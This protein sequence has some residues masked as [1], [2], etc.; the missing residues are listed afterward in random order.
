MKTT[1]ICR[2]AF[3]LALL[4]LASEP[5]TSAQNP[6]RQ[7]VAPGAANDPDPL[8]SKLPA[9]FGWTIT[10]TALVWDLDMQ[11]LAVD[12]SVKDRVSQASKTLLNTCRKEFNRSA[13]VDTVV[14]TSVAAEAKLNLSANPFKS[15]NSGVKIEARGELAAKAAGQ[16]DWKWADS[17]QNDLM[18]VIDN[19]DRKTLT[20]QLRTVIQNPK[21]TFTINFLNQQPFP[22]EAPKLESFKIPVMLGEKV[23][24]YATP[25]TGSLKIP[26]N[27]PRVSVR[28]EAPIKDTDFAE[29]I[30]NPG[31][32]RKLELSL[33]RS[34]G[35]LILMSADTPDM[36][37]ELAS[38]PN[39]Y[40]KVSL[41]YLSGQEL[42]WWVAKQ[43]PD[44]NRPAATMP[45]QASDACD[46]LNAMLMRN[47]QL[48]A[49]VWAMLEGRLLA[50][51]GC[52]QLGPE[53]V[54]WRI[55]VDEK[56]QPAF[57]SLDI[58]VTQSLVFEAVDLERTK[59]DWLKKQGFLKS[60]EVRKWLSNHKEQLSD[61]IQSGIGRCLFEGWGIAKPDAEQAVK[62]A[63]TPADRG[64]PEAQYVMGLYYDFKGHNVN[65]N[66]AGNWLRKAAD[67]KHAGATDE[68]KMR[69]AVDGKGMEFAIAPEVK[70]KICWI[71]AG[72]FV[73]GSPDSEKDREPWEKQHSVILS[74]PYWV[75]ET[76]VTQE[77]WEAVMG[78]TLTEQQAL[79]GEVTG[80]DGEKVGT[81]K[82]YP[83]YFVSWNDAQK[84]VMTL[85]EKVKL[86]GHWR[87]ALP[88]EAQ[89]E[90]ACRATTTGPYAGDLN[91]IAWYLV[92]C[93]SKTHAV[94][95]KKANAWGLYDTQGN[96][97]EW[98]ADWYGAYPSD[99]VTDPVGPKTGTSH[100]FRG[101]SW[102]SIAPRCRSAYRTVAKPDYRRN[103]LG[104][105]VAAVQGGQS[106]GA[107]ASISPFS[108]VYSSADT[109]P[110]K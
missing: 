32:L 41:R 57:T 19:K 67:Q 102:H 100:V 59:A 23:L 48:E 13:I 5:Q 71:P 90:Y 75:A 91:G 11:Q 6:D 92:N 103:F 1:T 17:Q 7:G 44:P 93:G 21:L 2:T 104:F 37:S 89:W 43:K 14:R 80:K 99:E 63:R 16:L 81:G 20:D 51:S 47:L 74:R 95:T 66:E 76:E 27:R 65:H 87:W 83:M 98:C 30:E 68:L 108:S 60:D 18:V 50:A 12:E 73:M 22:V 79:V 45:I 34:T 106:L 8:V 55:L 33:D 42:V 77:Q 82:N 35:T 109:R 69:D 70:M 84:F 105:R 101:G 29:V 58:P 56:D 62:W 15:L 54:W 10:D 64:C 72:K 61:G 52:H 94:A 86:P 97:W 9:Q 78:S 110:T 36:L 40:I 3:G 88:T 28:F 26:A 85:N 107:T 96:V 49:P 24:G 38:L 39:R 4:S 53:G 31:L 25:A 46:A